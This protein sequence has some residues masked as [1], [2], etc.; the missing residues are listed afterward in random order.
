M[1][2]FLCCSKLFWVPF[3]WNRGVSSVDFR[4]YRNKGLDA[5]TSERVYRATEDSMVGSSIPTA[6]TVLLG[7]YAPSAEPIIKSKSSNG[8]IRWVEPH[9]MAISPSSEFAHKNDLFLQGLIFKHSNDMENWLLH[10]MRESNLQLFALVSIWISRKMHDSHP[11]SVKCLKSLG[12]KMTK[13]Q[14]FTTRDF[15]ESEVVLMQVLDFEIGTS[16]IAF[17]FLEE[18]FIQFK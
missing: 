14:H 18:L 12:D 15:L 9:T 3:E 1:G 6:A 17:K 16:N 2:A 8:Q 10:P 7:L 13:E 5:L 4:E 11:L